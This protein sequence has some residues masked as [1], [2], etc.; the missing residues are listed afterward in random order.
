MLTRPK[1]AKVKIYK[2]GGVSRIQRDTYSSTDT[3]WYAIRQEVLERDGHRC[4]GC[5]KHKSELYKLSPKVYLNV[6]HIIAL[7][8]GGRTI[9]SNLITLCETCHTQRHHHLLKRGK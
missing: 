1:K 2:K 8:R 5:R 6:H 7:S 9:K 4:T 3:K